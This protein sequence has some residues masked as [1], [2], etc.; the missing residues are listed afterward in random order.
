MHCRPASLIALSLLAACGGRSGTLSLEVVTSPADDP[1][2]SAAQV[3]ITVSDG[4]EQPPQK[5]V[6]VSNGRFTLSF[7]QPPKNDVAAPILVEALDGS[8]QLLAWGR[9][10]PIALAAA[11]QGPYKIWVAR[12]GRMLPARDDLHLARRGPAVANITGLG[13]LFAGGL[14]ANGTPT[15]KS[16]IY[17]LF[18]H[19]VIDVTDLSRARAFASG[20][21]SAGFSGLVCFGAT[22]GSTGAPV[23]GCDLYDPTS[24]TGL[25]LWASLSGDAVEARSAATTI[26][27]TDTAVLL[28]GGLDGNG[29]RVATAGVLTTDASPKLTA[30]AVSMVTARAH[31]CGSAVG[32]GDGPGALLFG[33]AAAGAP[34]AERLVGQTFAAYGGFD[35]TISRDDATCTT[36]PDGRVLILGGQTATGPTAEGLVVSPTLPAASV[37]PLADLLSVARSRHSATLI[38]PHLLVCGGLDPAGAPLG[39][40]DVLDPATLT[41]T[42][43]IQMATPRYD[44]SATA[45][46]TGG[47]LIAGGVSSQGALT[48]TIELYTPPL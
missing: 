16:G 26:R 6:S 28:S 4:S 45:L 41:R 15:P 25:G 19:T 36:L 29:Q 31:H 23:T 12:P 5:T 9:S 3:R 10:P 38:G 14:D 39:S 2:S 7:D 30:A 44:H 42:A 22:Q 34:V 17:D 33:G 18:T 8:G 32:F 24:G 43:T 48:P 47:A 21:G 27:L 1:F 40:C 20:A 35:N 37:T 46:E 11:D 13:V